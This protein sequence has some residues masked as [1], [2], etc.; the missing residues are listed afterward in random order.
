MLV[1]ALLVAGA[2]LPGDRKWAVAHA[3]AKDMG[4]IAPWAPKS[5]FLRGVVAPELMAIRARTDASDGSVSLD[6]PRLGTL[7]VILENPEDQARL[8]AWLGPLWPN[9]KAP[10]ARVVQA[11]TAMADTPAPYVA[12][13]GTASLGALSQQ[14]GQELS[15]HRFRGNLWIN[16]LA[17]WEELDWIGKEIRIG[18]ARLVVRERITRCKATTAN[19]ETGL[20][21]ANT[22]GA[23]EKH[24][25]HRDFGV[26][27]EVIEGGPIATGMGLHR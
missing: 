20:I 7:T 19:P 6:H 22:L 5:Q 18:A 4:A 27:A 9:D 23:L 17:P 13:A 14:I 25:G 26:F 1:D 3:D 2:A 11:E 16:G 21:D 10:A 15:M 8:I 24:Y 12:I